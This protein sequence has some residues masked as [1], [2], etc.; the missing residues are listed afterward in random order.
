MFAN[1]G[2]MRSL[3]ESSSFQTGKGEAPYLKEK[4][5]GRWSGTPERSRPMWRRAWS[6]VR[7]ES[8]KTLGGRVHILQR[9]NLGKILATLLAALNLLPIPLVSPAVPLHSRAITNAALPPDFADTIVMTLANLMD[10]AWTPDG[11]LLIPTKLGQLRIFAD[12]ILLPTPALDLSPLLCTDNERGLGGIAVHPGFATNHYVYLY[13][14]F[15]KFGTCQQS[16]TDGPVNRLSR[17]IL[18]DNNTV[19]PVN[20][21]VL[22]DT[23][24]LPTNMHNGGDLKFGKDGNLYITVGDGGSACCSSHSDWPADPSVVLGKILRLTDS[25]GIPVGNPYTGTGTAR[26]NQ[27]GLPPLGSPPGTKC[28]EV[29]AKGLRNPFRFAFDPNIA[30]VHFFINDVG[31]NTWEEVDKGQAGADYGWPLREG[32]C[33]VDSATECGPPPA[34]LTNPIQWYGH[35]VTVAGIGCSAIT[36]AAFVPT[37]YWPTTYNNAYL[38]ADW[39][40][41]QVW[42]L[43]PDGSGGY[44]KSEFANLQ[45]LTPVS[46]RFG[47]YGTGIALYYVTLDSGGQLR[48][49]TY[50][51][52]PPPQALARNF[53]L[54]WADYDNDGSVTIVDVASAALFFNMPSRYWDYNL[55]GKDDIVDVAS[56][57]LLYNLAFPATPYPGQG[58]PPGTMDRSWNTMCGQ[59]P[60]PDQN[61][62]NTIP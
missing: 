42:A 51:G 36:G 46:M 34:G 8:V 2:P 22:L 12:N 35:N 58:L 3:F 15:K 44:L 49:I 16:E 52:N 62:C 45:P 47:P 33:A 7:F 5:G 25:G 14:T 24:P 6:C 17:F 27:D 41:G 60:S 11:R 9:R 32:P 29:Y 48:R 53:K 23:P 4:R 13:Y 21:Q 55:D 10:M 26:C 20:E 30:S 57:A 18:S 31:E 1:A 61:Y 19:N 50:T 38:F 56:V 37:G 59:L 39:G 54:D 43:R 28:Q 40:C